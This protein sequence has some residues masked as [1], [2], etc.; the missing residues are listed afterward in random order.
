M[1]KLKINSTYEDTIDNLTFF[2]QS[3]GWTG[4]TIDENDKEIGLS[5]EEFLTMWTRGLL[6]N[7][8]SKPILQYVDD[9][10]QEQAKVQKDNYINLLNDNLIVDVI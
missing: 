9:M 3:K 10:A 8:I 7:E 4:K 2:A 5:L 6:I 1:E